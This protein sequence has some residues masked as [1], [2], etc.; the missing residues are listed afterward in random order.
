[1]WFGKG[2]NDDQK[3][4]DAFNKILQICS[5]QSQFDRIQS[6]DDGEFQQASKSSFGKLYFYSR[7][8]NIVAKSAS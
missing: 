8:N 4:I 1:M 7:K 6:I 3:S 5:L 2:I